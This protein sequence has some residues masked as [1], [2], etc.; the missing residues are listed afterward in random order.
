[1]KSLSALLL[2]AASVATGNPIEPRQSCP[3][4]HVFGARETT[5]PVGYGTSQ[6]LVNRVLQTYPG[7]TSAA[8]SYPACGGQSSCGGVS[9]DNSVSVLTLISHVRDG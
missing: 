1:M 6:G 4:I 8:I 9:Y 3:G 2:A 7:S 5:A